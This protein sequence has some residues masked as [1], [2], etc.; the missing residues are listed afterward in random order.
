MCLTVVIIFAASELSYSETSWGTVLP[1][2][3]NVSQPP[4]WCSFKGVTC[5]SNSKDAKKYRRII[6]I[7]LTSLD[8]KGSIPALDNLDQMTL[9]NLDNNSIYGTIPPG[10]FLCPY[11]YTVCLNSISRLDLSNNQLTGTIPRTLDYRTGLVVLNLGSNQL[12]GTIPSTIG[13]L[14]NLKELHLDHN[15]LTGT[16]PSFLRDKYRPIGTAPSTIIDL[17]LLDPVSLFNNTLN[18]TIGSPLTNSTGLQILNLGSNRLTGTIPSSLG[19]LFE[20]A[21]LFLDNNILTGTIPPLVQSKLGKVL[22]NDNFLTMGSLTS[23]PRSTFSYNAS[24]IQVQNNCLVFNN[25]ANSSQNTDA[26][27][28][29]G[30]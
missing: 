25:P 15:R 10:L 24:I 2:Y 28:C 8:L 4:P 18:R 26:F 3:T 11:R 17:I 9:F 20:L 16:I 30:N 21:S 1:G 6:G 13:I 7:N 29:R 12:A 19:K 22:L 14:T 23:V 27:L 5:G